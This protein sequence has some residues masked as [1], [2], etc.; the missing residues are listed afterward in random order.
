MLSEFGLHLRELELTTE[1]SIPSARHNLLEDLKDIFNMIYAFSLI[2]DTHFP[3]N[4]LSNF[5][6]FLHTTECHEGGRF[7]Y[8]RGIKLNGISAYAYLQQ[9]HT[10]MSMK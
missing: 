9:R 8:G 6:H 7:P 5:E 10:Y 1:H 4:P 2:H 3:Q